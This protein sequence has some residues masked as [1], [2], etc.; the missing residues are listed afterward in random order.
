MELDPRTRRDLH[1]R[2]RRASPRPVQGSGLDQAFEGR[3]SSDLHLSESVSLR[4]RTPP[5]TIL[6]HRKTTAPPMILLEIAACLLTGLLAPFF[7]FLG[8]I[9]AAALLGRR[10]G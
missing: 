10:P 9:E 4:P 6:D 1:R 3:E 7:V 5:S 8:L 2:R